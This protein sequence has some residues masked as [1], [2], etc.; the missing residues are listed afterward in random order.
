[1]LT[2]KPE[3]LFPKRE[4][5]LFVSAGNIVC[6]DNGIFGC[7]GLMKASNGKGTGCESRA[8]RPL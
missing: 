4:E 3:A 2:G 7:R 8:V 5:C 1:M 6:P